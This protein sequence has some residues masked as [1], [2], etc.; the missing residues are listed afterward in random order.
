MVKVVGVI[1]QGVH[2]HHGIYFIPHSDPHITLI[3]VRRLKQCA[4][5]QDGGACVCV[6]EQDGT[7]GNICVVLRFPYFI[8]RLKMYL[9]HGV[10]RVRLILI[11]IHAATYADGRSAF[12]NPGRDGFPHITTNLPGL[13]LAGS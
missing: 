9:F 13:G 7:Q 11:P 2:A 8:G 6:N 5:I 1:P 12:Q 4:P 3:D 10:F